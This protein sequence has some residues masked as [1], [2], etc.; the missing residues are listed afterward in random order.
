[1]TDTIPL[2]GTT[3]K[4]RKGEG[5]GDDQAMETLHPQLEGIEK[6]SPLTS[7]LASVAQVPVCWGSVVSARHWGVP[8]SWLGKR[9]VVRIER[10]KLSAGWI[11]DVCLEQHGSL[12][13][14][15]VY[16]LPETFS[17]GK[18][19]LLRGN[20][21]VKS[22]MAAVLISP[23][24]WWIEAGT[25]SD[26][27]IKDNFIEG[28]LR[29]PIQIHAHGGDGRPL[30]SGAPRNTSRLQCCWTVGLGFTLSL[31]AREYALPHPF[32]Q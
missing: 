23:E 2:P 8:E 3:D 18:A 25:S 10:T 13:V 19:V 32:L 1:L 6:A 15:H 26:L 27:V 20:R 22:R 31:R 24:F 29:T 30:P 11:D 14:D 12:T 28:C 16:A 4:A 17:P 5:N 9:V 21:I 7:H